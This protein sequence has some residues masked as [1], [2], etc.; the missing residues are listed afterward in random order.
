MEDQRIW[1]TSAVVIP[2]YQPD[3]NLPA[4]AEKFEDSGNL[5]LVVDDG[6]GE[7]YRHIF[8]ALDS[9]CIVLR[10][11][12]NR[13]K[14]AALKTAFAYIEACQPGIG[15]IT[16][17]DADGQHLPADAAHV[18]LAAWMN[19]GTL[20]LGCREFDGDIPLRSKLGN[21][22]TQIVFHAVSGVR[23]HDTQTGLRAFDRSLLRQMLAI[24]GERYEYEMNVLLACSRQH[25]PM[26]EVPICTVYHDK[27][28]S[29]SHFDAVRDSFRIYKNLLKFSA[30]SI[31]SF[32]ADY[33]LFLA[34]QALLP[35]GAHTLLL[36]NVLARVCSAALN[37][38]LNSR[39]VFRDHSP[40]KQTLPRYA[41]LAAGILAANSVILSVLVHG[42]H[43]PAAL[44]K[45]LTELLLF[46][47]SYVVQSR[48]IF[49]RQ[50]AKGGVSHDKTYTGTRLPA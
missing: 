29:C 38:E 24:P 7:T 27:Q 12:H 32:A 5:I 16:T 20:T 4:L 36:G 49:R 18:A 6:S 28:N 30:S 39:A 44:A 19:P 3:E 47:L 45:I 21:K 23:L 34:L 50:E 1:A 9:S 2:A 11:E 48:F 22:I 15:V 13:G 26:Q 42:L 41:A 14:G 37:Y 43:L 31:L 17:V 10:H 35:A 25:I 33:G 8:D 46:S 40:A